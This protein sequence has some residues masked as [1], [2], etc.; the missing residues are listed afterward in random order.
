MGRH[1][2]TTEEWFNECK[3]RRDDKCKNL[4]LTENSIYVNRD[5]P[6]E[7]ECTKHHVTFSYSADSILRRNAMCPECLKEKRGTDYKSWEKKAREIHGN[8]FKYVNLRNEYK[9]IHSMITMECSSGHIFKQDAS[10]H[11]S[12]CGCRKCYE[13]SLKALKYTFDDYLKMEYNKYGDKFD[14]SKFK[15]NGMHEKSIY[16]CHCVDK[17][18]IEHG[19]YKQTPSDH[20]RS[21]TGCPKCGNEMISKAQRLTTEEFIEKAKKI[22]ANDIIYDNVC[23]VSAKTNVW[24]KCAKCGHK[25]QVTPDNHLRGE[26]CPK[27]NNSKLEREIGLFFD[28]NNI[29][30]EKNYMKG[31]GNLR[32]DFY[33]EK[34]N[35]IVECQGT[36]HFRE[37]YFGNYC[38]E[39]SLENLNYTIKCDV[40]KNQI[41]N[42]LGIRILYYM[43]KHNFKVEY[44]NNDKY[45][46][47]YNESNLILDK[48]ILLQKIKGEIE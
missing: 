40:R 34:Y 12:G 13:E 33:I 32:N 28:E 20:L 37:T 9:D 29:S 24:L 39:K 17:Y 18:G 30:Y 27:C 19:E 25:F 10:S 8:E 14:L 35:V 38:R 16:I 3:I 45:N 1:L 11:L 26:G 42:K 7:L 21:M 41:A 46:K 48:N 31:F 6:V 4:R 44:L 47:I 22:W 36:Q 5:K 43:D 23:Y 2:K 15:Y